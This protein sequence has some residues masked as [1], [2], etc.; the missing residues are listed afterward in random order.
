M[1]NITNANTLLLPATFIIAIILGT[2]SC[3]NMQNPGVTSAGADSAKSGSKNMG[4]DAQFLVTVSGINLEEI[5]LGQLAQEKGTMAHVK[6]LGKMMED[7]HTKAQSDLNA[8]ALKKSITIPTTLDSNAQTDYKKLSDLSGTDFDKQYSS[9]MVGGHKAAINLFEKESASANDND[10]R[11]M[12][13]ATLPTLR[14]HL[15][16]STECQKKCQNNE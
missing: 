14:M 9:M 5:K 11:Q 8:L 2:A 10:I 3:N 12:A 13:A 7:D 15:E 1:K 6:D 4:S 16:H